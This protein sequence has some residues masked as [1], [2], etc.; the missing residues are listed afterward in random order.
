[1]LGLGFDGGWDFVNEE[2]IVWKGNGVLKIESICSEC[3]GWE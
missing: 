3:W 2:S 1:M